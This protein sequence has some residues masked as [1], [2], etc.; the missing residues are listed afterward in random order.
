M[1]QKRRPIRL[2]PP[3]LCNQIAA[4]EVVD[5]P[6]G[7]VKELVENSLDAGAHSIEITLENGGQSLI[8]VQD[9]GAGL[10]AEE[11][12][13]AVTRHATSKIASLDDLLRVR[14][15]G[16]RGEALP[17]IASVSSFRMASAF[18]KEDGSRDPAW[19]VEVQH[20]ILQGKAP[21]P[22]HRGS[23]V[24]VRDLFANIPAR[25]KFLKTPATEVKRVQDQLMR[26]ALSRTDVALRLVSG[27][28][29]LICFPE[30]QQ[31]RDRLARLWPP[32]I[33]DALRSFSGE[34][35]GIR[36]HGL[37]GDPRVAQPRADRMYFFVNGRSIADKRVMAAV[38]Q[39][40]QGRLT[41]RD[42]PQ[43]VLFLEL[44]PE[45]VDVNV[46]PAK[47]EVRF[48]DESTLFSA[49]MRVLSPVISAGVDTETG[50]ETEGEDSGRS[51]SAARPAGFWGTLDA[52]R[53]VR[54][55]ERSSDEAVVV[56]VQQ[57]EEGVSD[58][59]PETASVPSRLEE[60]VPDYLPWGSKPS[61]LMPEPEDLPEKTAEVQN[62][63]K[64]DV[65]SPP[66][67][68][69]A[70]RTGDAAVP[71]PPQSSPEQMHAEVAHLEALTFARPAEDVSDTSA[72]KRKNSA[73]SYL[74]Q[75]AKT[76]LILRDPEGA[77][78]VL[79]QHAAHERILYARLQQGNLQGTGQLL[80]LPLELVLH[81][82]EQ[83]R[84]QELYAHLRALGFTAE[85][86]GGRL[87]VRSFPPLLQR[88]EAQ[89]FLREV[90]GGQKDDMS[91]LF[92]SMACKSAIKAGQQLTEDEA[93]G[94]LEQWLAT[95]EREFCP[96]GRPCILR[97][98]P[99]DLEKLF[100]R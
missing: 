53:M 7:V 92:A 31:L 74:G 47:S 36:V 4:G 11:L 37:A 3:E 18:R 68:W 86:S 40:Y 22:L 84:F 42:Y 13:L 87:T 51:A 6:A 88:R 99:A 23:L 71:A 79:D 49:I 9:D 52:P 16:F 39:V 1:K 15:F 75:V 50:A 26:L 54:V 29:E 62:F 46:H 35:Q 73:Y 69:K 65:P 56:M 83:E 85:C 89:E 8:R 21:S 72:M 24:E 45:E 77:L 80:A 76:Y 34:Y 25:L 96:H 27:G 43:I 28:R 20:G 44:D 81:P 12:E 95:P 58:A 60:A 98:T 91:S 67:P 30:K 10:P 78:V 59:R 66:L 100:K 82:A 2:L 97:W 38:R 61:V 32:Q 70:C 90:L 57:E 64:A 41:T 17:S 94:L 93:M 19:S 5:R 48:R 14:S 33:V 63:S 55:P